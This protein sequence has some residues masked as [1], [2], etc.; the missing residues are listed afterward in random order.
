MAFFLFLLVNATLFIRPAEIIPEFQAW[1]VYN[2]LIVINLLVAFPDI[3]KR[4]Q[5]RPLTAQPVLACVFGVLTAIFLSHF[6]KFDFWMAR[7]GSLDFLKVIAYFLILIVVVNSASRLAN[8]GVAIVGFVL[9]VCLLAVLHFHGIVEIPSLTVLMQREMDAATGQSLVVPRMQATGIFGD[10]NDL[11]MIIVLAFTLCLA[12]VFHQALG[13]MRLLS[14][15]P[16]GFLGYSLVLTQSRG[17]LLAL[18]AAM[19]T[20]LYC[21]FGKFGMLGL[22]A[23]G[24]PVL[25]GGLA[26]RQADIGG[27]L[28]GGTGTTRAE[29]WSEG[30]QEFKSA[31]IF[32]VGHNMYAD[33]VGQVA[34]NSFLHAYTELGLVGGVPFFGVFAILS[35]SLSQMLP[36]RSEIEDPTLYHLFPYVFAVLIGYIVS[37]MSLSRSYAIPTYLTA[38]IALSYVELARPLT[39]LPQLILNTKVL[40]WLIL[41]SVALIGSI[42][43]Y[44]IFLLRMG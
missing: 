33:E 13:F 20:L 9:V 18:V 3:A 4:F 36:R 27:A 24:L 30:L 37:M 11:S 40:R 38:G 8:F 17:G 43:G 10:P 23:L 32:G 29:L 16:C 39:S 6:T 21:R 14:V 2:V 22:M 44:V 7:M 19:G 31:P 12:S 15:V 25:L 5:S 41:G 1:P 42:Y 34:H 35:V 26:G 28:S